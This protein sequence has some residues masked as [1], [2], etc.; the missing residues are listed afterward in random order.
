VVVSSILLNSAE[1]VEPLIE[2]EWIQ[3][4]LYYIMKEEVLAVEKSIVT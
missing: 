3:C 2:R 1:K 4:Y